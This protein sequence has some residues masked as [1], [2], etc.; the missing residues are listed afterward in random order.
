MTLT[1]LDRPTLPDRPA[2]LVDDATRR[3][4]LIGGASLATLLAGCG[5]STD[6]EPA[7]TGSAGFPR[8]LKGKE[9]PTAIPAEPRRVVAVGFQRDTDTAIALG[10]TP[11]AMSENSAIFP[12]GVAPWVEAAL[13]ASTPPLVDTTSRR[14]SSGRR[15]PIPA[16]PGG[17]SAAAMS[18]AARSARSRAT[19]RRLSSSSWACGSP[20]LSR[21]CPRATR[22]AAQSSAQRTSVS[23][24]PT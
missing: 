6:R 15:G 10:V 17:P 12:S 3:Q 23:S 22:R 20:L 16:S 24:R 2:L 18:T 1:L 14:W 19:C 5:N 21:R 9:G 11:V 4:F 8:T 7:A 13:T